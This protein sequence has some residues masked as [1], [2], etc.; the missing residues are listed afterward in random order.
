MENINAYKEESTMN[1]SNSSRKD[2]AVIAKRIAAVLSETPMTA[3]EINT[4]LGEEYT[5]LQIAN[6]VKCISG[7]AATKVRRM[8]RNTRGFQVEK[9]YAAYSLNGSGAVQK[10]KKSTRPQGSGV[11]KPSSSNAEYQEM[12]KAIAAV[13][14]HEPMTAAEINTALEKEY[15]PL[16][17]SNAVKFISGAAATKVRRMVRNTRGFQVEKEYAAYYLK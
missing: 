12:A 17:I 2:Y 3:A 14:S 10:P 15:S 5:P 1:Q 13:L 6:A 7:A 9:E 16:Q 4:A 8:V 11:P